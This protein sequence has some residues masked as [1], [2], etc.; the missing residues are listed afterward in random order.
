MGCGSVYVP[1]FAND[2]YPDGD[3]EEVGH[4]ERCV[5]AKA[6]APKH[7]PVIVLEQTSIE[8]CKRGQGEKCCRYLI[9]NGANWCCAKDSN[10][11]SAIDERFASMKAKGN[12]CSGPPN[13]T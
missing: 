7:S 2:F 13:F 10:F 4:C 6:L 3:N 12:N 9:V 5:I 8:V 11:Q 1:N